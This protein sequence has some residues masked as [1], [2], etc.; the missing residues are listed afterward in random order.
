MHIT[1]ILFYIYLI[2]ICNFIHYVNYSQQKNRLFA[3]TKA[4]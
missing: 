2:N 4:Y 3:M 1:I